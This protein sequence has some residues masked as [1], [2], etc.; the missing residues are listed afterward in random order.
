MLHLLRLCLHCKDEYTPSKEE[1]KVV[2]LTASDIKGKS[3]YRQR[4]KGCAKC[5]GV[6][7]LGRMG[8]HELLVM[9]DSIRESLLKSP[10]ANAIKKIAIEHGIITLRQSAVSKVLEGLTSIEEAVQK[11]QTEELEVT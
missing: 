3:I 1:L 6:G 8:V 2:E 4:S 9:N 10:D 11:T 5:N 7:Y